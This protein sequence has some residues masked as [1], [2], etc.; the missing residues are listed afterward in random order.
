MIEH[1]DGQMKKLERTLLDLF[2][3]R[4][5]WAIGLGNSDLMFGEVDHVCGVCGF[6]YLAY[7]EAEEVTAE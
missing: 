6:D 7:A 2:A 5:R 4:L 1:V 3:E